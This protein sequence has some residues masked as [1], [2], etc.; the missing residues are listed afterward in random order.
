M[1][2]CRGTRLAA[3]Q[4]PAFAAT[5]FFGDA[6]E[7]PRERRRS[8]EHGLYEKGNTAVHSRTRKTA[9]FYPAGYLAIFAFGGRNP[10]G[11]WCHA[12]VCETED[13]E[14]F[15]EERFGIIEPGRDI[16]LPPVPTPST[17]T[18][19]WLE[20]D[21]I[22]EA[23]LE[24]FPSTT[25]IMQKS[26]EMHP[27]YQRLPPDRRLLRR[28]DC[29]WELFQS[30][31]SE[32][33]LPIIRDGF[34]NVETFMSTAQ[35][36]SQ[37]RKSRSGRSL[38]HHLSRI[39]AETGFLAGID[40]E[41]QAE[42]EMGKKPD[43]LFPTEAAYHDE[44]F[45]SAKL[46]MLAVKTSM[47]ERWS[48]VLR[49]ADRIQQK[50]LLTLQRGVPQPAF[51]QITAAKITLVVP[52]PLHNHYLKSIQPNLLTLEDFIAEVQALRF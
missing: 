47:K 20:G 23:W 18:G 29:E 8:H 30:I 9:P 35:I 26:L 13:E 25:D 5:A 15:A 34:Q 39:F 16:L 32:F 19:C 27:E 50:H 14:A 48:Q 42:T 44:S 7:S 49:E 28:R 33:W 22:P 52:K 4:L 21:E 1:G 37:R 36:L 46:R 2:G 10:K 31:E 45:D 38:E 17:R 24:T 12:W 11:R 41:E 40:F 6:R 43:F 3:A 51:D